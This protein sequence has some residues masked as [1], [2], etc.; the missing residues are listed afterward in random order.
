MWHGALYDPSDDTILAVSI[1]SSM[2]LRIDLR[3]ERIICLGQ[4][5]PEQERGF[6][7]RKPTP[8]SLCLSRD[9]TIYHLTAR[10]RQPEGKPYLISRAHLVSFSLSLNRF[11]DHG[12]ISI[13]DGRHVLYANTLSIDINN[14]LAAVAWVELSDTARVTEF[15]ASQPAPIEPI[16][17]LPETN[18]YELRLVFL[19]MPDES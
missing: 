9:R 3:A 13:E 17:L 1:F 6:I 14:R 12:E 7:P 5:C 19:D 15:L 16:W 8:L 10:W 11:R 18:P 2:L 4:L